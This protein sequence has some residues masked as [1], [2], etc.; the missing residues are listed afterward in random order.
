[1]KLHCTDCHLPLVEQ[2][3]QLDI[4]KCGNCHSTFFVSQLMADGCFTTN[5]K[6]HAIPKRIRFVENSNGF[7]ISYSN[8]NWGAVVCLPF[9]LG[10]G[11]LTSVLTYMSISA[12]DFQPG[13]YLIDLIF[14]V[15]TALVSYFFLQCS[16]GWE[17]FAVAEEQGVFEFG[18]GPVSWVRK[19]PWSSVIAIQNSFCRID[20][21]KQSRRTRESTI[22]IQAETTLSMASFL[23]PYTADFVANLVREMKFNR[24]FTKKHR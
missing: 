13:L 7:E 21:F 10:F 2:N 16:L 8:R 22:K 4:A 19:F 9:L 12:G 17:R 24:T 18:F 23:T 6:R 14:L 11:A 3:I 15:I 1:M 5:I 20:E